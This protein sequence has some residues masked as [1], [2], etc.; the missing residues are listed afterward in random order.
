MLKIVI[1][2]LLPFTLR[3]ITR[4]LKQITLQL[5]MLLAWHL[6]PFGVVAEQTTPK[7]RS[8]APVWHLLACLV[9]SVNGPIEEF[10]YSDPNLYCT[11][12]EHKLMPFWLQT[13]NMHLSNND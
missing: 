1:F 5:G 13:D 8:Q 4:T 12:R 7:D 6:W 11:C 9:A 3:N 2:Q 10:L